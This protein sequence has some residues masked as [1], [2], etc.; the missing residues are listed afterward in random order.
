MVLVLTISNGG[1][2]LGEDEEQGGYEFSHIG[3]HE[4]MVNESSNLPKAIPGILMIGKKS[5]RKFSW[6][7]V[8]WT[9]FF[10]W[11]KQNFLCHI[12]REKE[13]TQIVKYNNIGIYLFPEYAFAI[14][15][16]KR[17]ELILDPR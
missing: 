3:L 14:L 1:A 10:W 7:Q 11:H 2:Q 12:Y 17:N 16:D 8:Y 15:Q 4:P 9:I 13:N 5:S 6:W